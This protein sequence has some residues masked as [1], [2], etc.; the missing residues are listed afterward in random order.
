MKKN[1]PIAATVE[2]PFSLEVHHTSPTSKPRPAQAACKY[3]LTRSGSIAMALVDNFWLMR[4]R[5]TTKRTVQSDRPVEPGGGRLVFWIGRETANRGTRCNLQHVKQV[6]VPCTVPFTGLQYSGIV[7]VPE[8]RMNESPCD[9][10]RRI[11]VSP[12]GASTSTVRV[13]WLDS[14][15]SNIYCHWNR[16]TRLDPK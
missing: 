16:K 15:L 5:K 4:R 10:L 3:A 2:D 12:R 1:S 6:P 11:H 7:R 13:V 8:T 14:W 9:A